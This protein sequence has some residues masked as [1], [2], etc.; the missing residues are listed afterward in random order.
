MKKFEREAK[1][2]SEEHDLPRP[3][4]Y[5]LELFRLAFEFI[6][7]DPVLHTEM[8]HKEYVT[9]SEHLL[10]FFATKNKTFAN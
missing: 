8:L 10:A 2:L 7:S 4:E 1:E 6:E 9:F 3:L 5:Y